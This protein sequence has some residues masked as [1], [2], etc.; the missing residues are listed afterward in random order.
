M[1]QGEEES[2]PMPRINGTPFTQTSDD[3]PSS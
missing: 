3:T 2:V 1:R